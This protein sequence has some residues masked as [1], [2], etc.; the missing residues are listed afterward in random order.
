MR[1]LL[2][3][4]C[5]AGVASAQPSADFKKELQAGIDAFR[6]GKYEEARAYLTRARTIDRK[7]GDPHRYL[8]ALSQAEKMWEECMASAREALLVEPT[9]KE[10]ADTRKLHAACRS[11]AGLPPY[12]GEDELGDFAAIA[13]TANVQATVKI[14]G[15]VFGG[16]P[17]APRPIAPGRL[18]IDVEK[19]GYATAHLDVDVVPGIVTDVRVD[20]QPGEDAV[21]V[22]LARKS[23]HLILPA[24]PAQLVIDGVATQVPE[25]NKVPVSPG[26][27]LIEIRDPGKD[28]WRRRV[29]II[30]EQDRAITPEL[31]DSGP[32][33][34][35]RKLG[36]T[37][38]GGAAV[39]LGLG[40]AAFYVSSGA[41]D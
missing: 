3:V 24:K 33:E 35:R 20:L 11:A 40:V 25:G 9:S 27:H 39:L 10:V 32:R 6:L 37:L 13:I 22:P 18:A 21:R 31:V 30:A 15:L 8:A 4:I 34:R 12:T 26:I 23:G 28:A 38:T 16:T 19:G 7:A 36:I 1:S 17:I 41:S 29:A 2:L 5:L 14:R